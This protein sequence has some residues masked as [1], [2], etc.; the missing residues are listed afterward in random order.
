M[1]K[2][3]LRTLMQIS[4]LL[5][6]LVLLG[7]S[8]KLG[9]ATVGAV[10]KQSRSGPPTASNAPGCRAASSSAQ[11]GYT[12][13]VDQPSPSPSVHAPGPSVAVSVAVSVATSLP[14]SGSAGPGVDRHAAVESAIAHSERDVTPRV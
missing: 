9:A 4:A 12:P 5:A 6:A 2:H 8:V 11:S 14:A 7:L 1:P 13:Q 3:P 10:A